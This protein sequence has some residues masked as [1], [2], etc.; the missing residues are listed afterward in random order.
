VKEEHMNEEQ[1]WSWRRIRAYHRLPAVLAVVAVYILIL[2]SVFTREASDY[3]V[4][5]WEWV[6]VLIIPVA[7]LA[8]GSWYTNAQAGRE[9]AAVEDRAQDEALQRYLDQMSNLLIDHDLYNQ[10][11]GSAAPLLAVART[12]TILLRLDENRKRH[13]LKL[14]Y[15]LRLINRDKPLLDLENADLQR[16]DLSEIRLSEAC[17][18]GVD[19]R[20]ANLSGSNLEEAD[21]EKAD[22][23]GADLQNTSLSRASLKG[24]NLLPY[25]EQNPAKLS[26]HNL[27]GPDP[28]GINL[29]RVGT[30][31][32][33]ANLSGTNLRDAN[34]SGADLTGAYLKGAIGVTTEELERQAKT[35]KGATMPDGSKHK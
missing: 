26:F 25:D 27:H 21:L 30:N 11:K 17:L 34:L 6:G 20:R 15:R 10:P 12:T 22:L 33:G 29:S 1:K 3:K 32:S 13:P 14:V 8:A 23:R 35:L 18:R 31:L 4:T 7:F 19:L 2:V 16:A 28:S 9:K 24:A 5:L